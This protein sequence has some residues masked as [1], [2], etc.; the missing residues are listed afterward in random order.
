M[1]WYDTN[2][3]EIAEVTANDF[4]ASLK[5]VLTLANGST[6]ADLVSPVIKNGAGY[7]AGSITDFAE[8]GV[9]AADDYTLVYTLEAPCPY[10]LSILTYVCFFPVYEP[11][12]NEMNADA[13]NQLFGTTADT[14][15]YN[16]AY[17]CTS[18]EPQVEYVWEKNANYWDADNV[19]ITRVYGRYNAEADSIA[20]EMYLRGEIDGATI[21]TAILDEWLVREDTKNQV[22]PTRPASGSM[23]LLFNFNPNFESDGFDTENYKLAVNNVNFRKSIAH[24]LD[25]FKAVSAYDPYN[26]EQQ[27]LHTIVQEGFAAYAGKD[28]TEYGNL[29]NYA[30]GIFDE[31]VA[32]EARDAAKAELAEAG[33]TFPVVIPYYYNPSTPNM[34]DCNQVVEQQLEA[35]LGT[36]YID[37]IVM[38][39]LATDYIATVRRPG[40]WG[41]F[42]AKW[43]PDYAD[44]ATYS[45]P[46]D[47]GWT[48]GSQ[49]YILGDEYNTGY[50]YTQEDLNTSVVTEE[51]LIGQPQKVYNALVQHARKQ[52]V[53]IEARYE[54][55]AAA[56]SYLLDN[57]L[58]MPLRL[59]DGGYEVSLLDP[60]SGGYAPFGVAGY[61]YKG[62]RMLETSYSMDQYA[63]K[64]AEW[65]QGRAEALAEAEAE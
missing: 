34:G 1:K 49:E 6:T 29:P 25:K 8:V 56:D 28:Y 41:L 57:Y 18:W 13:D 2:A 30:N 46:F 50:V 59:T 63:Q 40:K 35:L 22:H 55:F 16:G 21:T 60:F 58:V 36:D 44:P 3:K 15:L 45:D 26:A 65:E 37:I 5:Y 24:G 53:D 52:T 7:Y 47:L 9:K 12:L 23:F 62:K 38:Q 42:E 48:F 10:F 17:I 20:P 32:L 33:V 64:M 51:E 43:G 4:V 61:R 31:A 54:A 11:F 27:M 14:I 39:G 19:F